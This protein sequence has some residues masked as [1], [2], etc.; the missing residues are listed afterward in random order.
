M[1]DSSPALIALCGAPIDE[2][3]LPLP[4]HNVGKR[5]TQIQAAAPVSKGTSHFFWLGFRRA[6][7]NWGSDRSAGTGF[8]FI[9]MAVNAWL[10]CVP[11]M[12]QKGCCGSLL[13]IQVSLVAPGGF[14]GRS[15]DAKAADVHE[16]VSAA[17]RSDRSDAADSLLVR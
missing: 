9:A 2:R 15:Q 5:K 10:I 3:V 8:R 6:Q 11:P 14:A 1:N 12:S 13:P 16:A 7:I 4:P 17:G